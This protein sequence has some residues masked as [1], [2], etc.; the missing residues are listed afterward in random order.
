MLRK[1]AINLAGYTFELI[2]CRRN[3][4]LTSPTLITCLRIKTSASVPGA[5]ADHVT[6]TKD[7]SSDYYTE[8]TEWR[9][10]RAPARDTSQTHHFIHS[11]LTV[12]SAWLVCRGAAVFSIRRLESLHD[13][14]GRRLR[15]GMVLVCTLKAYKEST[16]DI[17]PSCR[18]GAQ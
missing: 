5:F 10:S 12:V 6:K 3:F 1:K 13:S 17:S 16:F 15:S 9:Q 11:A 18:Q 14:T 7:R 2:N 4:F 8:C